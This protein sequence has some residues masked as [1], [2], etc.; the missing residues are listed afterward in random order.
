MTDVLTQHLIDQLLDEIDGEL[1]SRSRV[2]DALL[3]L[4]LSAGEA[5]GF[6]DLVDRSLGDVPG[7]TVVTNDWWMSTLEG[8]RL[9]LD[10]TPVTSN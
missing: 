4:R 5:P 7:R 9:L 10:E 2:T 1:I 8:L 6:V 3:D